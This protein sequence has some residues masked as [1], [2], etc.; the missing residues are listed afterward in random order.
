MKL[1]V[2]ME[3]LANEGIKIRKLAL[4]EIA[5]LINKLLELE[6][7]LKWSGEAYET[8]AYQYI[9]KILY[10][11][12]ITKTID[13]IGNFYSKIS[14]VWSDVESQTNKQWSAYDDE[15]DRLRAKLGTI[16]ETLRN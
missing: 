7:E 11:Y 9:D 16:Q 15:I 3:S 5:P 8:F 4:D 14:S 1:Y 10:L 13:K 12:D 6:K 2:E